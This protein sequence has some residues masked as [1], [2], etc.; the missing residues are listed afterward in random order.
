MIFFAFFYFVLT[1][2]RHIVNAFILV[3]EIGSCC[4]YV[5]FI[6]S[7]LK[8]LVDYFFETTVDVRMIMVILLLPLILINWVSFFTNSFMY[9]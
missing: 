9:L 5:V 1:A 2:Y 7:N 4:I 6:A 3:Y 8:E